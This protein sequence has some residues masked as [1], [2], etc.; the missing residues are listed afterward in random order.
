VWLGSG[1]GGQG[2]LTGGLTGRA[3]AELLDTGKSEV[4][5]AFDPAQRLS[6][7]A[8]ANG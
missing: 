6:A 8:A 2:I 5:A 1:H 3:L 4:A 7:T